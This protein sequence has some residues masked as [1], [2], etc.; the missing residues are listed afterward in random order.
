MES[1]LVDVSKSI[2]DQA[3]E[4]TTA[5]LINLARMIGG[6]YVSR[7]MTLVRGKILTILEDRM[8][9][10]FIDKFMDELGM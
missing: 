7:E 8:G 5:T 1:V 4:H 3:A 2:Q 6:G 10:E 9:V